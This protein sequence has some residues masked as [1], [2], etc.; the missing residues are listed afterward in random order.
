VSVVGDYI[1]NEIEKTV[2]NEIRVFPETC[3][4]N[5]HGK[6]PRRELYQ[7]YHR[8][9]F[10]VFPSIWEEPFSRVPLESMACGT[11][12]ISTDN[13]GCQELFD[14]GIPLLFLDRND[15]TSLAK[16]IKFYFSRPKEYNNLSKLGRRFVEDKY[17]FNR[18]M[19]NVESLIFDTISQQKKTGD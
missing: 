12:C 19:I 14:L 18:F 11:P 2:K 7:H 15:Q 8:A 1:D 16:T 17:T 9:N 3:Q 10:T 6:V 5:F 13:P 4:I